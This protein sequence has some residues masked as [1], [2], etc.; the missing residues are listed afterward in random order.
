MTKGRRLTVTAPNGAYDVE[1]RLAD[2]SD[3]HTVR[4]RPAGDDQTVVE[5]TA[6]RRVGRAT[7][8]VTVGGVTSTVHIASV[9]DRTSVFVDG[10]AIE[11]ELSAG[12][13]SA[14][15][16]AA[17]P[18]TLSAPMP[19]TVTEILVSPGATVREGDPLLVL[20]A[21][22]MELTL[23]APRAGTVERI[24]CVTGDLVQPGIELVTIA[25]IAGRG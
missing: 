25:E 4:I 18:P 3:S 17:A 2:S 7:Y 16:P 11:L 23:R 6:I 20:E 14:A 22:K 8:R 19:A 12:A 10:A 1:A 21:M 5:T 15:R 9:E 13:V 24:G